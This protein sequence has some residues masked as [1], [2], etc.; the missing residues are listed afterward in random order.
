MSTG[1]QR[2]SRWEYRRSKGGTERKNG[3]GSTGEQVLQMNQMLDD[4]SF[5]LARP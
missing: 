1:E 3:R 5:Y 2:G 4:I